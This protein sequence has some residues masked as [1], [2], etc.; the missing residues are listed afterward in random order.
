MPYQ[1]K[2]DRILAS[3]YPFGGMVLAEFKVKGQWVKPMFLP[4]WATAT[5]VDGFLENLR[6]D[7]PCVPFG[8][9]P[10][11]EIR[12]PGW[13]KARFSE[14]DDCAHG[15]AAHHRWH[16]TD[17]GENHLTIEIVYPESH[18]IRKVERS[19]QLVPEVPKI[20]FKDTVFPRCDC[21]LPI[22]L[23][24]IFN[25]PEDSGSVRLV[26]PESRQIRT[27]PGR[28]DDSSI[29]LTDAV[30]A[31]PAAVPLADGGSMDVTYLPL[32]RNTEELLMLCGVEQGRVM[33]EREDYCVVLKWDAEQ[34]PSCL[35]WFSNHGRLFE[36]WCGKNLCLGV[37]PIRS[38]FDLGTAYST[39]CTPIPAPTFMRFE[40]GNCVSIQHEISV[41]T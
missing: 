41:E 3:V 7:F 11:K 5:P 18:P 38:A 4:S 35:L 23:H 26:L 16:L 33:L 32:E 36:P 12:F 37:E 17:Q 22:G 1:V 30:V 28:V 21:Q 13:Q 6:G 19:L 40:G 10:G 39:G 14:P 20:L 29:F 27:F 24:P 9:A 2:S 34:L 25:L 31:D 15:F 8:G